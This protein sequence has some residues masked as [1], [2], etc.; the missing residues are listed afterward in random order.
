[1]QTRLNPG[2][3]AY[4]NQQAAAVTYRLYPSASGPGSSAADTGAY[5]MG[6]SFKVTSPSLSLRG[7]WWWMA[8]SAQ[9]P[10]PSNF[11]LWQSAGFDAGTFITGSEVLSGTFSLGWNFTALGTPA[12]LTSGQ[13]YRAVKQIA[14]A[15]GKNGYSVV[16]HYWDTGAGAAGIVNGPLVAYSA[17]GNA[18]NPEP[19]TDSQMT[20]TT[21]GSDVTSNYPGGSFNA[22]NYGLDIQVG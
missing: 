16:A 21:A 22:S 15:G 10:G 5:V 13:E 8:D 1:M 12:P 19:S 11:A 6:L 3:V 7:W 2:W 18:V 20:F 17:T 14:P 9:D 4:E